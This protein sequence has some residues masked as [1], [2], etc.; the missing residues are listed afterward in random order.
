MR[1]A[2]SRAFFSLLQLLEYLGDLLLFFKTVT[3]ACV[4]LRAKTVREQAIRVCRDSFMITVVS[5]LFVGGIF[6]LQFTSQMKIF[7]AEIYVGGMNTSAVIRNIGPL[8][9]AFMLSGKIGAFTTAEL[10]TMRVTD[11]I[12]ALITLGIH[13]I[14]YL[15]APRFFSIVIASFI[16]LVFSFFV[17]LLGGLVICKAIAQINFYQYVSKIP[18]ILSFNSFSNGILKSFVFGV[19]I[20]TISCFEG[21]TVT[22]GAKGVG[23][24]VNTT[25]VATSVAIV[26]A[27]Y[28]VTSLC[29]A[30]S[31]IL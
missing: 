30:I 19:I 18:T 22:G 9:V 6:A 27:N 23:R 28:A 2:N 13:P 14:H 16:L 5:A 4:T 15:I 20:A 3:K 10:G 17:S 21:Y 7:G 29:R 11:Q 25:A 8:L 1:N 26:F 31:E 12:D 24:A